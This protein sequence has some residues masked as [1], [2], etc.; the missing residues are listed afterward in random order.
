M[1]VADPYYI[2]GFTS[3]TAATADHCIAEL[4]NPGTVTGRRIQVVEIG[5]FKAGAGAAND[6]IYIARTSARG[7]AGSTVTPTSANAGENDSSPPSGA[8]LD[9]AAFSVQPT[10]QA[11]PYMYGWVAPAVA[12]A[13]IIIPFPRGIIV[14][15]GTGLGI[16]IRAAAAWPTSEVTFVVED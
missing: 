5:I 3:A 1:A 4:W 10:R 2:R 16:F 6:S 8:L 7:T 15:S 14:P 12:G 13:G 9:L 11:A